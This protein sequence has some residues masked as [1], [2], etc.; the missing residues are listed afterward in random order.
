MAQAE[1]TKG[2]MLEEA[3]RAYF[4]KAGYFVVRGVP[5]I[6]EGFDVTDVDIWL[7]GRASSVSREIALVD[8][9]N[10]KTPQA[11]ERIFWTK[12]LQQAIKADRAIVATTEKRAEVKDFGRQMDVLVLDGVFLSKLA[13]RDAH[14]EQRLSDEEFLALIGSYSLAKVD[15][16][17]KGRLVACK[18]LLSRGLSFDV[19]NQLLTQG[20]FFAEQ[21]ITKPSQSEVALRCLYAICGYL[22]IA[23][24]FELRELSFLESSDRA[25]VIAEGFTYGSKGRNGL[26]KLID[27][28]LGLV[29]EYANEGR[30]IA[31]QVRAK[32]ER[33]LSDIPTGILGEFF[34][35][36]DVQTGLF[37]TARE[38][39]AFSM[40]RVFQPHTS[41]STDMRSALGCL[42]D[43]WGIDRTHLTV[44]REE[45]AGPVTFASALRAR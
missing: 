10:K 39:E 8:V 18:G 25:R 45:P 1:L 5:F 15:G 28:S 41:A 24:D 17:W 13:T 11:I 44:S 23:V 19:C 36:R 16:D 6:F 12:G 2:P 38:F 37:A 27:L 4:L 30:A 14:L 33:S 9:K 22:L 31:N 20:K 40:A 43:Y 21:A 32:V 35:K 42:L 7:Y 3:L 34:S 29:S 26:K